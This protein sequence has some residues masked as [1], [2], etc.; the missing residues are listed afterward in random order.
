MGIYD[1]YARKYVETLEFRGITMDPAL[2]IGGIGVDK[3]TGRLSIV[4]DAG[5]AFNTAGQDISGTNLIMQWDPKTRKTLYQ[6]NLTTL[7]KGRYGGPQDV[8]H[9]PEGNIYT[10]WTF[11]SALTKTDKK[12]KTSEW[13]FSGNN[14]TIWGYSGLAA[15]EWLLLVSDAESGGLVKFDMRQ[16][17]GKPKTIQVKPAYRLTFPDAAYLPPI[18]KGT[19]L[20]VAEIFNGVAVFESKSGKWDKAEYKGTV[21]IPDEITDENVVVTAV[22][23]VGNSVYMVT[24]PGAGSYPIVPGTLGGNHS[25]FLFPDITRKVDALLKR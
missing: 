14:H 9:D 1:P 16:K 24:Q 10:V 18:Y 22:I 19:V 20:L 17:R 4:V 13:Y 2:H 7:S 6:F 21:P 15:K 3:G 25:D 8:E 12:G 5:A 23:Q 11:S